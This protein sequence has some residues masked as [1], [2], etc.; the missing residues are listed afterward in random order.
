MSKV[1]SSDRCLWKALSEKLRDS[2]DS[3]FWTYFWKT[4]F[5]ISNVTVIHQQKPILKTLIQ[6]NTSKTIYTYKNKKLFC[7]GLEIPNYF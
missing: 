5:H 2:L 1:F 4:V 6:T 7:E 3:V